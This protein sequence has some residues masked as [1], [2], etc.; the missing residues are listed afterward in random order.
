MTRDL[1]D[2][3][4]HIWGEELLAA[5]WLQGA[6][7][8]PIKRPIGLDDWA[9]AVGH[10]QAILVTADETRP[11][12]TLQL[13][14][15]AASP[16]VAGVVGWVDLAAGQVADQLADLKANPGGDK[17]KGIR[18]SLMGVDSDWWRDPATAAGLAAIEAAG[19]VFEALIG[20]A[21]LPLV[22]QVAECWP[23]LTVVIDHLG[24]PARGGA[25]LPQWRRDIG[26]VAAQPNVYLK[27]SGLYV[28]DQQYGEL[29]HAAR[30]AFG[31][32]R[33]MWGSDYPVA[34]LHGP[35]DGPWRQ[36]QLAAA[37]WSA[38]EQAALFGGTAAR[39]YRL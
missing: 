2:S 32:E 9:A 7:E 37:T 20:A 23:G 19:L 1:I 18:Q 22:A 30:V 14:R 36:A 15:A 10:G 21:Q 26:Q 11:G 6:F 5:P 12:Q 31:A 39:A 4:V 38:Q 16:R 25:D 8:A 27:L 29:A 17:L 3:H 35:A 33:L 24:N 13:A 34:T 28:P